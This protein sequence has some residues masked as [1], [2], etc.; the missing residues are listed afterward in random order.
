MRE[1]VLDQK[2]AAISHWYF[3]E[4]NNGASSPVDP[5]VQSFH[6][7]L[8]RYGSDDQSHHPPGDFDIAL[9]ERLVFRPNV[10]MYPLQE[11]DGQ[12]TGGHGDEDHH[13]GRDGIMPL[14]DHHAGADRARANE[15]GHRNGSGYIL[16][17]TPQDFDRG[18]SAKNEL[19]ADEQKYHAAENLE[20]AELGLQEIREDRVAQNSEAA[21]DAC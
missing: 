20:G 16:R 9:N 10:I 1:A 15:D 19:D 12:E 14:P 18:G 6:D 5:G 17:F 21:K 8:H 2:C 4:R 3:D 11:H 7:H 13:A